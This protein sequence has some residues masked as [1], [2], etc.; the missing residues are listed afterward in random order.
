VIWLTPRPL[1]SSCASETLKP[2]AP[3][4]LLSSLVPWLPKPLSFPAS[5][6]TNPSVQLLGPSATHLLDPLSSLSSPWL[7]ALAPVIRSRGFELESWRT[8]DLRS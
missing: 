7:S 3:A 5:Q 8:A 1:S 2:S 6:L 4:A